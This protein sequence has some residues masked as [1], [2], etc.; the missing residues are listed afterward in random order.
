MAKDELELGLRRSWLHRKQ[1]ERNAVIVFITTELKRRCQSPTPT[2]HMWQRLS[3]VSWLG[4]ELWHL[5]RQEVFFSSIRRGWSLSCLSVGS[6]PVARGLEVIRLRPPS[7][8]SASVWSVWCL[9]DLRERC[10]DGVGGRWWCSNSVCPSTAPIAQLSCS[11]SL[12]LHSTLCVTCT[13]Q[14]TLPLPSPP[15]ERQP[16][17][18]LCSSSPPCFFS[19]SVAVPPK[20]P[21]LWCGWS[22]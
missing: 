19:V 15:S 2:P 3:Q 18:V 17:L 4:T 12:L 16:L 8:A 21:L 10:S 1:R 20:K 5:Q 22:D 9:R 13:V 14:L 11:S 6:L 7:S